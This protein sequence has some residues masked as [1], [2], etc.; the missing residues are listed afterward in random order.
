[1]IKSIAIVLYLVLLTSCS[2]NSIGFK[3]F[4]NDHKNESKL[5]LSIPKWATMPFIDKE[6][7]KLIKELSKGMKSVRVLIDDNTI[8]NSNFAD[9]TELHDYTQ[10][11][12]VKDSGDEIQMYTRSEDKDLREIVLSI[13]TE[14][15]DAIIAILGKANFKEFMNKINPYLKETL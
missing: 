15:G 11:W 9:Y 10:Y 4:Y 7:R 6:D 1:M 14:S 13:G 2:K 8:L 12:Y 5:A 3:Q